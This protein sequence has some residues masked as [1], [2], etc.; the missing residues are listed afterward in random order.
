V[1]ADRI[2]PASSGNDVIRDQDDASSGQVGLINYQDDVIA[3]HIDAI[4][5]QVDAINYRNDASRDQVGAIADGSVSSG[6]QVDQ[7]I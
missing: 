6:D 3:D 5:D 7:I 1:I 2:D 4:P